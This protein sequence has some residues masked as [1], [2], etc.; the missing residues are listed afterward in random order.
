MESKSSPAVLA[1]WPLTPLWYIH[2]GKTF[3][4]KLGVIVET[5]GCGA[6]LGGT[7]LVGI[8]LTPSAQ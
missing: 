8:G 5:L 2:R 6:L 7:D 3:Q 1:L 4:E